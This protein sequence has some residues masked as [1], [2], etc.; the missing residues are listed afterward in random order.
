MY[1][2]QTRQS[3]PRF[4]DQTGDTL[5][6]ARILEVHCTHAPLFGYRWGYA[7]SS[8][9][10]TKFE[11]VSVPFSG[12]ETHL[13]CVIS[14]LAGQSPPGS[15]WRLSWRW[16]GIPLLL[17]PKSCRALGNRW[18]S[19]KDLVL[20][21]K[22]WCDS[23]LCKCSLWIGWVGICSI[24]WQEAEGQ[25]GES[26]QVSLPTARRVCSAQT[27]RHY[28]FAIQFLW[29][30]KHCWQKGQENQKS[31]WVYRRGFIWRWTTATSEIWSSGIDGSKLWLGE[32]WKRWEA[33]C[34]HPHLQQRSM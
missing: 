13:R 9:P 31:L 14:I 10:G 19:C 27:A 21:W 25:Q 8:I 5:W 7:Q 15:L 22:R 3:T 1:W 6:H 24:A 4:E 11:V 12:A 34:H 23:A 29:L 26:L 17:E 32:S 2:D 28:G 18:E 20:R 33:Q 16:L 30:P